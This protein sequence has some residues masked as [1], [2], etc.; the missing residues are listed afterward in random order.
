MKSA[1]TEAPFSPGPRGTDPTREGVAWLL[2]SPLPGG[3]RR[4]SPLP[5]ASTEGLYGLSSLHMDSEMLRTR[6]QQSPVRMPQVGQLS[7]GP[8]PPQPA[9]KALGLRLDL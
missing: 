5:N 4:A 1:E 6:P 3:P 2:G 9:P 7:L 8:E